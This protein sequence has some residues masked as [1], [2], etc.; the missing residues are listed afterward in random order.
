MTVEFRYDVMSE[1]VGL[2]MLKL[3]WF[4]Q[5][6]KLPVSMDCKITGQIL[7]DG[8]VPCSYS[9]LTNDTT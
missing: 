7:R 5:D 2:H 3:S 1:K 9:Q 6:V 8:A 4:I